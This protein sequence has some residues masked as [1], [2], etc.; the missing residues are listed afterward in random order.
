MRLKTPDSRTGTIL[1]LLELHCLFSSFLQGG[2]LQEGPTQ[3]AAQWRPRTW[4]SS[5]GPTHSARPITRVTLRRSLAAHLSTPPGQGAGLPPACL[6]VAVVLDG[7][8][9]LAPV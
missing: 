4:H 7:Q 2:A 9:E 6:G 8:P 5:P 3:S 1:G